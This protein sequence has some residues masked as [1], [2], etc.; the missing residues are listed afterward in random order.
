MG[1]YVVVCMLFA[2]SNNNSMSF[3]TPI[4]VIKDIKNIT[5][6]TDVQ[7]KMNGPGD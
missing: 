1:S 6:A 2:G 4:E 7:I 5:K 3:F